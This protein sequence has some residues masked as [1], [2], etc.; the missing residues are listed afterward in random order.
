MIDTNKNY[1]PFIFS[2]EDR[3]KLL[4]QELLSTT[5][6]CFAALVATFVV[7]VKNSFITSVD[8]SSGIIF[9]TAL[10]LVRKYYNIAVWLFLIFSLAIVFVIIYFLPSV[11]FLPLFILIIS[12]NGFIYIK[13]RKIASLFL[14]IVLS[15]GV[16]TLLFEAW[17]NYN[18]NYIYGKSSVQN[19]WFNDY[20]VLLIFI[21]I[22][23]SKIYLLITN[24]HRILEYL[25]E[26]YQTTK[27]SQ[28]SYKEIIEN[29]SL[30]IINCDIS[31]L[32]EFVQ[33]LKTN[34][35]ITDIKT[36]IKE[37]NSIV[38]RLMKAIRV[39]NINEKGYEIR[40]TRNRNAFFGNK[41]NIYNQSLK[42]AAY[43]E[44]IAL[45]EN[46]TS[47]ETEI[48]LVNHKGEYKRLKYFVK[49]PNHNDFSNVTYTY[50][51]ITDQQKVRLE[52][53]ASNERYR[54]LYA[55]A[56]VGIII[57]D[58]DK[59]KRGLDCNEMLLK[60]LKVDKDTA[61]NGNM[62]VL[63]PEYQEDGNSTKEKLGEIMSEFRVKRAT[64]QFEWLFKSARDNTP[65][66]TE[67]TFSPIEW[68]GE[69]QSIMFIKNVTKQKRQQ[70]LILQQLSALNKKNEEL[71]KYIASN[72]EL[73]NFAYIASH[74]LQAPLRTVISFSNLLDKSLKG[75]ISKSEE[76]YMKF[77]VDGTYHMRQ[78]I[79][80]LLAFSRVNTTQNNLETI[81]I[82]D[83]IELVLLDM[84]EHIEKKDAIINCYNI[85]FKIKADKTK[86]R[87]LIQN[88]VNNA[89]KFTVEGRN[90]EVTIRGK[91]NETHWEISVKDNGIGIK[92]E[93]QEQI[94]L[95]FK[96]L[97]GQKEYTGTGIGLA[98]CKKIVEQHKGRI[99]VESTKNEGST[100]TFTIAKNIE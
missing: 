66:W 59:Q 82:N 87:Q 1:Q 52:L 28:T 78:L 84:R 33:D 54:T 89:L 30:A 29:N 26:T 76:E 20:I 19:A 39:K 23:I 56:P 92:K 24:Y 22:L 44:I 58:I 75:K 37:N 27:K 48:D 38:L 2:E 43:N 71:E 9:F 70:Q 99:S 86:L 65:I 46:K 6:I 10:F 8:L 79:N 62:I 49:Y 32:Y 50:I 63:S 40:G 12:F 80:D 64:M 18:Y 5:I 3:E 47:F 21:G 16:L 68:E 57:L 34:Q 98:L 100:F 17:Y 25:F 72:L 53:K 60:I 97:H 35:G 94:F 88:L 93:F 31:S 69:M 95:M 61:L 74:D 15:I 14:K 85:D 45:F 11:K 13:D 51:D 7:G 36:Y 81:K 96:R 42:K 41:T 73:E 77:I 4:F 55:N 83:T 67:V 91:E 90:P